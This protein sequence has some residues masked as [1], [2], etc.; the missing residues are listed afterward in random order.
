MRMTARGVLGPLA[1][2]LAW[3]ICLASALGL[4]AM[5]AAHMPPD[6]SW[7]PAIYGLFAVLITMWMSVAAF[8]IRSVRYRSK[9]P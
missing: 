1:G 7:W 6:S 9:M 4:L 8:V 5:S 2:F 3:S